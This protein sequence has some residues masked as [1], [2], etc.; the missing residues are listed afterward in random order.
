LLAHTSLP[1]GLVRSG[2]AGNPGPFYAVRLL[3]FPAGN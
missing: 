2:P 3:S 1:A